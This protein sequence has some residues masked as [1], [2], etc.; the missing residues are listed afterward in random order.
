MAISYG[1]DAYV[2]PNGYADLYNLYESGNIIKM[3]TDKLE[4]ISS[5][6]AGSQAGNTRVKIAKIED[7][8]KYGKISKGLEKHNIGALVISGGG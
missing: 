4:R 8:N 6:E 2:I 5:L 7:S 3:D 1:I